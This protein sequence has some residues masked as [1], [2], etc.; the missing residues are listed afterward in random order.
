MSEMQR[1]IRCGKDWGRHSGSFWQLLRRLPSLWIHHF[2]ICRQKTVRP[3]PPPGQ[4]V[5]D[6]E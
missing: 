3:W 2:I 6:G 4:E 1:C 5:D